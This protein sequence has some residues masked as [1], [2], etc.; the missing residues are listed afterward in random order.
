MQELRFFLF[1][2]NIDLAKPKSRAPWLFILL[3]VG[4]VKRVLELSMFWCFQVLLTV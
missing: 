2:G 4:L 3:A 1:A